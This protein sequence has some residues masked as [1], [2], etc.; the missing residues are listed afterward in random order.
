MSL[1]DSKMNSRLAPFPGGSSRRRTSLDDIQ[2]VLETFRLDRLSRYKTSCFIEYILGVCVTNHVD[3]CSEP[4]LERSSDEEA[5][6]SEP[7]HERG[8]NLF[9]DRRDGVE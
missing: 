7:L 2:E 4:L 6:S 3:V 1:S 9:V 5:I 8:G